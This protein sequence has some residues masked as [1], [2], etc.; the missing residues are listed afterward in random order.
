MISYANPTLTENSFSVIN[1]V[2]YK[3]LEVFIMKHKLFGIIMLIVIVLSSIA[4]A[5]DVDSSI[6]ADVII[7]KMENLDVQSLQRIKDAAEEL[8]EK[9]QKETKYMWSAIE[10]SDCHNGEKA[11]VS[12]TDR[13]V[14]KQIRPCLFP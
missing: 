2:T 14:S 11:K 12:Q 1:K 10:I 8:I 7:E 4:C 5:D 13:N 6:Y 9:K 3:M